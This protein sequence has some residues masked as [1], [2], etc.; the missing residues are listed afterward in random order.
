MPYD[1]GTLLLEVIMV[2][3]VDAFGKKGI[4]IFTIV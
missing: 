1:F 4:L 2:L 3:G